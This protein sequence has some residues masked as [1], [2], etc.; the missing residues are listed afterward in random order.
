MNTSNLQRIED[1]EQRKLRMRL[2]TRKA[3]TPIKVGKS[4]QYS[5]SLILAKSLFSIRRWMEGQRR[6]SFNLA[7]GFRSGRKWSYEVHH[8]ESHPLAQGPA[9]VVDVVVVVE[10][11]L[12]W[13]WWWWLR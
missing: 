3:A 7:S 1:V 2:C 12:W 8:Y 5:D 9:F 4:K 6:G 13:M 11:P 10:G